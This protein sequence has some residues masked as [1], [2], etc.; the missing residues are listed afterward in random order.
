MKHMPQSQAEVF[1]N[2]AVTAWE[3]AIPDAK[4]NVARIKIEGRYPKDGFTSNQVVDSIVHIISG[5]GILGSHGR[6]PIKL[7]EHDQIHLAAGDSYFFEGTM[8][9]LYS[10][11]PPWT[12]EQTNHLA[13]Y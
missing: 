10:A 2:D 8:Q 5:N 7:N 6:P 3:Y 13:G 1:H 9:I 11:T 12:P 4:L